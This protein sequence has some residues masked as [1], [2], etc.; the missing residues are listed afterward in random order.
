MGN[1]LPA[2]SFQYSPNMMIGKLE[3]IDGS[4]TIDGTAVTGT[5]NNFI[6]VRNN[7]DN[8]FTGPNSVIFGINNLR[9]LP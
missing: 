2:T 1:Q 3:W 7:K 8:L 9:P 6:Q 4:T 5:F